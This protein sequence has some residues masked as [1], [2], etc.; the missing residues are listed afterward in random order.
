MKLYKK[1][2]QDF[3]LV[4]D[5]DKLKVGDLVKP[6][7]TKSNKFI[8]KKPLFVNSIQKDQIII[9]SLDSNKKEVFNINDESIN[10]I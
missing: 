8:T 7:S 3:V 1:I 10:I 9:Q 2:K 4:E 6:Y 5:Y